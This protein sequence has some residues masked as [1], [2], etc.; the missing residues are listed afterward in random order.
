[1]GAGTH[2]GRV[3]DGFCGRHAVRSVV[4]TRR[5]RSSM[6]TTLETAP[7][8][9]VFV[10]RLRVVLIAQV[11]LHHV[12]L[13][14]GSFPLWYYHE[15]TMRGPGLPAGSAWPLDLLLLLNQT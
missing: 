5:R 13:T 14:Y 3:L 8:A 2:E 4:V 1:M 9:T 12:A 15:P 6:S 7:R 11:V 10:D